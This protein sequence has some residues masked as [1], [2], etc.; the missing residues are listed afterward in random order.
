MESRKNK[1]QRSSFLRFALCRAICQTTFTKRW[2]NC[3]CSVALARRTP[4]S[5]CLSCSS[6]LALK[7]IVTSSNRRWDLATKNNYFTLEMHFF[8]YCINTKWIICSSFFN[9]ECL[10]ETPHT[11]VGWVVSRV[12]PQYL[13]PMSAS[14][15]RNFVLFSLIF[16]Y[17][18]N[19]QCSSF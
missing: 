15:F 9:V 8:K 3:F 14:L 11:A 1:Q 18:I 4:N 19:T 10:L 5:L 16:R 7:Y 13:L 6:K 17:L 12:E 2:C